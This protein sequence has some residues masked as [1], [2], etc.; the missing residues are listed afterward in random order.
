MTM[1]KS[2]VTLLLSLL[3]LFASAL[4]YAGPIYTVNR[5]IGAGSVVGTIET[6]GTLGPLQAANVLDWNLSLDDGIFSFNLQ[7]EFN[8]Q[9]FVNSTGFTASPT[10]LLFDFTGPPGQQVVVFQQ[11]GAT[12]ENFWCLTG[13]AGS[14]CG[15]S[16]AEVVAVAFQAFTLQSGTVPVAD[17][18]LA[19]VPEPATLLFFGTTAVG[20]GLARWRQRRGKP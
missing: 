7:G 9:V 18:G 8:S 10:N 1:R 20:L 3:T 5:T 6:D 11:T 16:S 14:L 19:P 4:A 2:L 13:V 17:I 12:S 15:I